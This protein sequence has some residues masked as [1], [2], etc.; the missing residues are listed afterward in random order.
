VQRLRGLEDFQTGAASHLQVADDN[1]EE[2]LVEFLDGGV[3]VRGL[4]DVVAGFG[5]RLGEAPAQRIVVVSNQYPSHIYST[6]R[7]CPALPRP[8]GRDEPADLRATAVPN[9]TN[10]REFLS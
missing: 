3:T 10:T 9:F 7:L 5:H 8:T 6:A 1:I 4:L 2:P